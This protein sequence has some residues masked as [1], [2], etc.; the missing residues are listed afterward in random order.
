MTNS[1]TL[2]EA[3]PE[4]AIL[5]S[6]LAMRSKSYWGYSDDFMEACKDELTVTSEMIQDSKFH[7]VVAEMANEAVGFYGVERLSPLQF[8]LEAL[9]VDPV[10]IGSGI[11]RALITHARDFIGESGGRSLIIQGD[12]NAEEFYLA[13]GAQLIGE[14][15]SDS[16]PGRFLLIFRMEIAESGDTRTVNLESETLEFRQRPNSTKTSVGEPINTENLQIRPFTRGD[17]EP[18]TRFITDQESTRFL[19]FGDEQKSSQGARDLLE[20]TIA[21]YETEHPMLAFAVE[22][23]KTSTFIGFCGLTPHDEETIE[24]MYAI[25]PDARRKGYA[26]EVAAVLSQYALNKLG[27]LQVIAPIAPANEVSKIVAK[28]VGFQDNGLVTDV[29]SGELVHQFVFKQRVPD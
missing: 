10:H 16:I 27:Y 28:K 29:N 3:K 14:K 9:F 15:E 7:Y 8:E 18:F 12:P 13:V 2:R 25:M 1:L 24:I 5:L 26:T 20:A 23:L 21:S 6:G 17:S 4:E 22:A 11:G 19:T